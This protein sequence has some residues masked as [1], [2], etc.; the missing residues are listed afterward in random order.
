VKNPKRDYVVTTSNVHEQGRGTT[1]LTRD[2]IRLE[3]A[4][5]LVINEEPIK[6]AWDV[7]DR[8]VREMDQRLEP[9]PEPPSP[10]GNAD[11]PVADL[12]K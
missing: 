9:L 1:A 2:A 12:L 3:I 10:S 11:R 5:R 8:F 6:T 7:A 4:M